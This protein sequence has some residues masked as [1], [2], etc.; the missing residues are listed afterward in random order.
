MLKRREMLND[1]KLNLFFPQP[2]NHDI[3][4]NSMVPNTSGKCSQSKTETMMLF[5]GSPMKEEQIKS[6]DNQARNF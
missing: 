5:P 1:G 3:N 2:E 4:S 6:F